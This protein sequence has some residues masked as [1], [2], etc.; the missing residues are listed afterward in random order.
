MDKYFET[1]FKYDI[2]RDKVWKA[3]CKY[4]QK[5][6][7]TDVNILELG[8]GYGNFINNITAKNKLALD[9]STET[10]D[11][12]DKDVIFFN[13]SVLDEIRIEKEY[14]DII[15]ASNFFEHFDNEELNNIFNKISHILKIGGKLILIQP[16]YRYC[17]KNYFDDFTHKKI[18]SHYSMND[19][20][21]S[22]GFI[23]EYINKRFIPFSMKSRFPKSYYLT[24]LYLHSFYHPFAK[25]ML[26]VAVKK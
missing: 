16:N 9:C 18:F 2:K 4:L 3:I 5:F 12:L 13:Q 26:F 23:V 20:L 15:F 11:Y 24:S 19:F 7:K 14:L 25:Q 6:I 22:K 21:I 17:Y 8:A 10:K 1:R